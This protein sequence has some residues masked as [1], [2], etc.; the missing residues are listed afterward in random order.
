MAKVVVP[1]THLD[2]FNKKLT[3]L[4]E[5]LSSRLGVSTYKA[6]V[7]TLRAAQAITALS[8]EAPASHSQP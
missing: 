6:S 4:T 1:V 7:E 3:R 2:A 5:L 8:S